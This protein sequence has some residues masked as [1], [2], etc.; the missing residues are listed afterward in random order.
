MFTN[1]EAACRKDETKHAASLGLF[2][3][4]CTS[5]FKTI[6]VL[7]HHVET[8]H[9]KQFR[10]KGRICKRGVHHPQL[11]LKCSI[12][13]SKFSY[14]HTLKEHKESR[15]GQVR[16]GWAGIGVVGMGWGG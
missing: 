1:A 11:R 14:K 9:L 2:C 8:E 16:N 3:D 6:I 12:Y 7:D 13:G 4:Q 5:P 10:F 15:A